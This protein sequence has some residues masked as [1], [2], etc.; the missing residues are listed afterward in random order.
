MLHKIVKYEVTEISES[1]VD[2]TIV[3]GGQLSRLREVGQE[4]GCR[5]DKKVPLPLL[6]KNLLWS[7]L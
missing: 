6:W 3:E 7:L 2:F 5:V 1:T 4:V